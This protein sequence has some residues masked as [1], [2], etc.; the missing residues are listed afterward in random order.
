M[1]RIG[2]TQR[3]EIAG[4][5]EIR[6]TLDQRWMDLFSACKLE[7]LLLPNHL[8]T[9]E[10]YLSIYQLDGIILSGGNDINSAPK[11]DQVETRLLEWAF[12]HKIPLLGVCRGMQML[13][14]FFSGTLISVAN[15]VNSPHVTHFGHCSRVTNSF[16][17]FAVDKIPDH[18]LALAISS[19][20]VIES[21]KH[22]ELPWYGIMW[23][24]E[25]EPVFVQ[26]DLDFI[27]GIFI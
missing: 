22:K 23:H 13:Q 7:P 24:P 20:G 9:I 10:T 14:V 17:C 11:R 15:H 12:L 2:I 25:R 5:H 18:F 3:E 1:K 27:R 21:M 4:Q 26:E 6:D 19:D 8:S 16:H